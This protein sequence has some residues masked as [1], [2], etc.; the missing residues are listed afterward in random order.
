M[1]NGSNTTAYYNLTASEYDERHGEAQ[2]YE[3]IR[4]LEL[5]A[6]RY[7]SEAKSVLDVGTGTG[8]ALQ[9][10]DNYYSNSGRE[11]ELNGVE[12]S[13]ELAK[14]ARKKVPSANIRIAS[15]EGLPF[16]DEE[17]DLVTITGVLHHVENSKEV[18]K[19]AFR[20]SRLGVIISDHNNFSFGSHF[21]RR[22]KLA[23]YS[24]NLL[25]AF[26]FVKQGFRKQGYSED[27]GWWYPYSLLNDFDVVSELSD[28]YVI[29]PTRPANSSSENFMT[30]HS[31]LALAC[32]KKHR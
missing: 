28:H 17:F 24:V 1:S 31:H 30:C 4:A 22:L 3:H 10:F 14:I 29:V 8:R 11:V 19:E 27:D 20:V 25:S 9:W 23:L 6:P 5:I 21:A 7:F 26:S 12:P 2:N 18:L 16:S 15:G 32:L 13:E